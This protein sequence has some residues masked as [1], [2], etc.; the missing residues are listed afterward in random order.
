MVRTISCSRVL[1]VCL[2]CYNSFLVAQKG[3]STKEESHRRPYLR[4][5]RW[6]GASRKLKRK[7]CDLPGWGDFPRTYCNLWFVGMSCLLYLVTSGVEVFVTS[8]GVDLVRIP[9]TQ[10]RRWTRFATWTRSWDFAKVD[11]WL[12]TL[13]LCFCV[14]LCFVVVL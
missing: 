14:P 1:K 13:F 4:W 10:Q 12:K 11:L 7:E 3:M 9:R 6:C 2:P 5:P 8:T